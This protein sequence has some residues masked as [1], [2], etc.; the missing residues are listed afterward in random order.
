LVCGAG[1]SASDRLKM[2]APVKKPRKSTIPFEN[3]ASLP[4]FFMPNKISGIF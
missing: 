2:D 3:K 4:T 1:F